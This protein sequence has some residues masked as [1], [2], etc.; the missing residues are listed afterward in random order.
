MSS[1]V[2]RFV[3]AGHQIRVRGTDAEPQF[4]AK[5]V[6]AALGI[7]NHRD[8][9]RT[10][11]A[12]EKRVSIEPTAS[13]RQKM[14][15]VTEPGLYKIIFRCREASIPGTAPYAFTEWVC[16]DVLPSIRRTQRYE[17][18]LRIKAEYEA[19]RERRLWNVVKNMDIYTFNARRRWFGRVCRDAKH[20]CVYD[21][22]NS[23]HVR[24]ENIAAAQATIRATMSAAI[25][26]DVPANQSL[27]THYFD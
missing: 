18:K 13:G 23:P 11:N 7:V 15:F 25:V 16:Y 27:I 20:L 5:D 2:Q 12:R 8:K 3:H 6:C 17:I 9:I 21:S 10:L 26:Q 14:T 1:I 19:E 22:Q 4:C 24:P